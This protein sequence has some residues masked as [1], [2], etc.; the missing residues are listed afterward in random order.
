MHEKLEAKITNVETFCVV[1]LRQRRKIPSLEPMQ[2]KLN[3][4]YGFEFG[5]LQKLFDIFFAHT[6]IFI[7]VKLLSL[8]VLIIELFLFLLDLVYQV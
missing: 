2:P 3:G 5:R 4:F 6:V 8:P 1:F 7:V